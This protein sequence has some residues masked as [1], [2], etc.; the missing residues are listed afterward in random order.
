MCD[1]QSDG[2]KVV[3][4]VRRQYNAFAVASLQPFLIANPVILCFAHRRN[5]EAMELLDE[6]IVRGKVNTV[7]MNAGLSS[8]ART[9][10]LRTALQFYEERYAEVGVRKD[11]RT[12]RAM[13][14]M[15]LKNKRIEEAIK[16]KVRLSERRLERSY[17]KVTYR[18]IT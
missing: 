10:K 2:W 4:Y 6:A 5:D 7:V 11:T 17:S 15:L 3:R 18:L 1:E 16:V 9:G 14:G 12:H 8:I 13:I